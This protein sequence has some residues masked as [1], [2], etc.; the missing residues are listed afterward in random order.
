MRKERIM[1]LKWHEIAKEGLPKKEGYYL[2]T[3]KYLDKLYTD[4]IYFRGK[5]KWAKSNDYIV[6]WLDKIE[7]FNPDI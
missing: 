7:P 5:T 1:E 4:Y 6:A 3:L 2:V